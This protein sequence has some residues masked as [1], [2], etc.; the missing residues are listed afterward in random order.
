MSLKYQRIRGRGGRETQQRTDFDNKM[1]CDA[2]LIKWV[3]RH[4]KL[5]HSAGHWTLLVKE[6][7]LLDSKWPRC[8]KDDFRIQKTSY[9][10]KLLTWKYFLNAGGLWGMKQRDPSWRNDYPP[11]R[12][13]SVSLPLK[14][15]SCCSSHYKEAC[16]SV[17]LN[18]D[19]D[20]W[21]CF[22]NDQR[23]Q[24]IWDIRLLF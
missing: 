14:Y 7:I 18:N 3:K 24:R 21:H 2:A 8:I 10:L 6:K 11:E 15:K 16:V 13:T 17:Y 19:P 5:L 20:V 23:K 4:E 22:M 1:W 9:H 12:V